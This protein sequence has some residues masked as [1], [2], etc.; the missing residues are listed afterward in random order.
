M[1]WTWNVTKI[2]RREQE[3]DVFGSLTF[4]GS[5]ATG[6]DA[7]GTLV[8]GSGAA[9]WP[10]WNP[11]ESVLHAGLPATE[12]T[13]QLD[14]GYSGVIVPG[15]SGPLPAKIKIYS[16]AGTELAAGAYPGGFSGATQ[17]TLR[18]TYR[19]NL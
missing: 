10:Q 18:Q 6:G 17:H 9:G 14:D 8:V 4:S 2:V 16:A 11:Q 13:L 15:S 5:Y 1:A 19:K 7:G 12:G 3:I